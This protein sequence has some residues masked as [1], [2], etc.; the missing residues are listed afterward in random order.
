MRLLA[1]TTLFYFLLASIT[2]VVQAE[3]LSATEIR[4]L[5]RSQTPIAYEELVQFL[6]I[7]NFAKD[8]EGIEKN[9]VW[10]Q[11]AFEKRHFE[12]ETLATEGND[13]FF[14][15]KTSPGAQKTVLFYMHFDGQPTDSSKWDQA[16]PFKPV[17]KERQGTDQ[18]KVLANQQPDASFNDEWRVFARSASDDK[19]PIIM[20]LAALDILAQKGRE[21]AFNIKVILDSE[22]EIGSPNLS[23]AVSR[24]ADK[25]KAQEMVIL[26]GPRHQ[27][28]GPT[29]L[30]GCRGI[31]MLDL[32][33]YGPTF[34]QHSGHYGNYAPNPALRLSQLLAS[35]KDENGLVTI[36]GFYDGVNLDQEARTLLEAVP[37]D[38]VFLQKKIG[39]SQTDKVGANYQE[40]IQYPSLNIVGMQSAWVGED[41]RTIVPSKANAVLDIRLVPEIDP[42][43]LIKLV[44]DHIVA[45]GYHLVDGPPTDAMRAKY[46]KL[47]NFQSEVSSLAFRTEPTSTI[48]QWLNAAVKHALGAEPIKIRMSG[49]TVPISHFINGLKI[50]A[51]LV[52]LVNPDNNQHSPNENLRLGNFVEGIQTCVSILNHI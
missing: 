29:L 47:A 42:N 37:D 7:P 35:M 38:E 51:V 19:S 26:D 31:A 21:P 18:W 15:R 50:Q 48:G 4:S 14:A 36:P 45:Q 43:R 5:S 41:S 8:R 3:T 20:F 32:T 2:P 9:L 13:L 11:R 1:R 27:T 16:D 33:V 46:P 10:L 30:F 34:P 44:R 49:G 52:P 40:S 17:L 24:Y 39:I 22:E 28:N 6:S 12:T 23:V 25:L